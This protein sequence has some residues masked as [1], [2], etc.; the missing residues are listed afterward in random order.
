MGFSRVKGRKKKCNLSICF[1]LMKEFTNGLQHHSSFMIHEYNKESKF[2]K[3]DNVIIMCFF[4]LKETCIMN[5]L[6]LTFE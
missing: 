6:T 4:S 1:P 2:E 3:L 5:S